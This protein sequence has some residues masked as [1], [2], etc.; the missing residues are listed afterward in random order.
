LSSN[1]ER[2]RRKKRK[3]RADRRERQGA[4]GGAPSADVTT[5]PSSPNGTGL[6]ATL[7][8]KVVS[9]VSNTLG[10]LVSVSFARMQRAQDSPTETVT[11]VATQET[12]EISDIEGER[13]RLYAAMME[14][15]DPEQ[16]AQ[17]K[18]EYEGL[19]QRLDQLCSE[20]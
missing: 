7:G 20:Q 4:A 13:S 14:S 19:G 8:Q 11:V 12:A 2:R 10:G 9:I 15:T 6:L 18:A 1:E 16:F 5:Q 17:L 3:K